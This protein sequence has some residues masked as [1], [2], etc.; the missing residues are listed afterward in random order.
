M[1]NLYSGG[2]ASKIN[3]DTGELSFSVSCLGE[4]KNMFIKFAY[5]TETENKIKGMKIFNWEYLK[6]ESR[7][8]TNKISYINFVA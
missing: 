3:L 7:V 6:D 5:H 4:M 2:F 8:L 1:D